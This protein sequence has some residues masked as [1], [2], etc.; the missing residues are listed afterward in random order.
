[1]HLSAMTLTDVVRKTE[2]DGSIEKPD[3]T[4]AY[5]DQPEIG[6]MEEVLVLRK[7]ALLLLLNL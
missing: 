2:G 6:G 1:M 3:K 5:R 4:Y 7:D